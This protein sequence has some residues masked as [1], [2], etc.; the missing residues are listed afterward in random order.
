MFYPVMKKIMPG[1]YRHFKGKLYKVIGTAT[2]SETGEELVL[3]QALYGR[4]ALYARPANMFAEVIDRP[5]NSYHGPRF[6]FVRKR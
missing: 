6:V 3:Y 5:E 2:H 1:I 4:H